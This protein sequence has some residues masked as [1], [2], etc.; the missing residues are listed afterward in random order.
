MRYEL[1][2]CAS[3]LALSLAG[4]AAAAAADAPATEVGEVVVTGSFIKGTPE[5]AALPVDVISADEIARQGA[6]SPLEIIKAL[7]VSAGALGE[8]DQ[9]TTNRGANADGQTT[10]N[11]RGFGPER[12][13]VLLNGKRLAPTDKSYVDVNTMP[14]AA[15]GRIEV[16]KDGASAVYGS[17]AI[18]GVVNFITRKN[19]DGLELAADYRH[20]R[21]SDGD[22]TGSLLWGWSGERSSILLAASVQQR[23]ALPLVERDWAIRDY[24]ANPQGGWT[25]GGNPGRFTPLSGFTPVGPSTVDPGCTQLG[26]VQSRPAATP[27]GF[28]ICRVQYTRWDNLVETQTRYQLF[29]QLDTKLTD[30]ITFHLDALYASADVPHANTSPSYVPSRDVP[31]NI[32]PAGFP[33]V[34]T[35]ASPPTAGGYYVPGDNP[36]LAAFRAANPSVF[37]AGTDG[38]LL[39]LG[40]WRPFLA[41][42]TPLN[43]YGP[44][45]VHF[46]REQV[47]VSGELQGKLPDNF[48][49]HDIEWTFGV[50]YGKYVSLIETQDAV[51]VRLGLALR[52][53]GGQGCDYRT[54]VPGVGPCKWLNPFS[55]AVPGAPRNG[56]TNP[57]YNPAV[58]NNDLD[59]L[60]WI[61]PRGGYEF[62][63]Q[64]LQWDVGLTGTTGIELPGGSV[65]WAVGGQVRQNDFRATYTTFFNTQLSPCVDTPLNGN[66]ACFP[67]PSSPLVFE[68]YGTP[69]DLSQ[70]V[71]AVYGEVNVPLLE[72][73][74]LAVAARYEDYGRDG[75]STFNPEARAKWQATSWL[76]FRGSIGTTFRAP[77]QLSLAP[78]S[79]VTGQNIFGTFIP[80]EIR[81]NPDLKPEKARSFGLG[82]IVEAGGFRGSID[83][84]NYRF[85]DSLT[86]EPLNNVLAAAFGPDGGPCTGDSAFIESH[87]GF[88]SGCDSSTIT[89]VTTT[90]INGPRIKTSGLDFIGEYTWPEVAGG[91]LTL[92]GTATY[93]HEYKIG[94][95]VVGGVADES[96]AFDAVGKANIDT[97]A[98]PLPR[99]K[100][101]AYLEFTR[102]PHNLRITGRY[103]SSYRDQRAELFQYTR[104]FQTGTMAECGG[105]TAAGIPAVTSARCGTI[106]AGQKLRAALLFDLAYQV[107]LPWDTTV[108]AAMTNVFDRDPGFARTVLNYDS[109][110]GD[111]L[112]RT[113]KIGVR[114]SF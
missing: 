95:L 111:P 78:I 108:T 102:G 57:G 85:K 82:A 40:T 97:V 26:G 28:G 22:Y 25:G 11:L 18:G 5:N 104:S 39:E 6:P 48:V 21:G 20:I 92:G 100:A 17:D 55:N 52:G 106:S 96:S 46:N 8:A 76:A 51:N 54:G 66:G 45:Q 63:N 79:E 15:I 37:P 35:A 80:V 110:T 10:V 4:G 65:K 86:S 60:N 49:G 27:S 83:Y 107:K 44:A 30:D 62:T 58:A 81:G 7:P 16:L 87:F 38:V 89:R 2:G 72:T 73:L 3:A 19:F 23:S 98:F 103:T 109:L 36:G 29:A 90:Q 94:A 101:Q 34:N 91:E 9:F 59:L 68:A 43:G 42:G 70:D 64:L 56:L 13:L 14:L 114:K 32:L 74:N 112:G 50:T 53:L 75:G 88:S 47:R 61:Y 33:D 84:W 41:G 69:V 77:P 12:T 67:S 1:M 24:S 31:A 99:W 93:V 105:L 113:F 71:G